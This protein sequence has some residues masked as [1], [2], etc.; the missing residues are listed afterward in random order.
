MNDMA[1]L[2]IE[3]TRQQLSPAQRAFLESLP[4]TAE[5]GDRLYVHASAASP[6]EWDYVFDEQGAARSLMA[7]E[8]AITLCGHTHVP[9]LF[10]MTHTGKV[11]GF[12]P[13]PAV[14][15]PLSKQRQWIAVIGAVG[16][17]RDH[18]PAAC[19]ALYDD[20]PRTLTYVRVPYDVETAAGKIHDAG[21]PQFLGMRLSWGR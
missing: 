21:L 13:D 2:A 1:T 9:A 18:N 20:G 10:Y 11:A 3:W 14:A 12:D 4:L 6:G 5:D 19:Y 8:S 16:Q 17:P 7:T 15:V